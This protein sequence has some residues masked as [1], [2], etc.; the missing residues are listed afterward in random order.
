MGQPRVFSLSLV[1]NKSNASLVVLPSWICARWAQHPHASADLQLIYSPA[2]SPQEQDG[3]CLHQGVFISKNKGF[4]F[5]Q[6]NRR[7]FTQ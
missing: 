3:G 5:T 6:I 4:L 2:N 7:E 1:V